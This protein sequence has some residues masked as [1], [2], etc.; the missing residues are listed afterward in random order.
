VPSGA[1]FETFVA[2]E[3]RKFLVKCV[4]AVAI[5]KNDTDVTPDI[6]TWKSLCQP[7]HAVALFRHAHMQQSPDAYAADCHMLLGDLLTD[8]E[9][10]RAIHGT[11]PYFPQEP[12]SDYRSKRDLLF[13]FEK[14]IVER[15]WI[16]RYLLRPWDPHSEMAENMVRFSTAN[17]DEIMAFIDKAQRGLL[18][19]D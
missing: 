18:G 5:Y 13:D 7:S 11:T 12:Q 6:K 3:Y 1:F 17:L 4:E 16:S 8:A 14:Q 2:Q 19:R 15:D 10:G 9:A